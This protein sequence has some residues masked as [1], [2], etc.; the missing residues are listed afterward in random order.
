MGTEYNYI[1]SDIETSFKV[2]FLIHKFCHSYL[3]ST[4]QKLLNCSNFIGAGCIALSL[5]LQWRGSTIQSKSYYGESTSW[6]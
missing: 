3:K 5:C 1:C 2:I 6:S 4:K